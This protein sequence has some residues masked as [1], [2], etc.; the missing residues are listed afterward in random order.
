MLTKSKHKDS[1]LSVGFVRRLLYNLYAGEVE[2]IENLR[3]IP[4]SAAGERALVVCQHG[5]WNRQLM[6]F[7][8][9]IFQ[10]NGVS[11]PLRIQAQWRKTFTGR[12]QHAVAVKK[13][14]VTIL[15][16]IIQSSSTPER[17]LFQAQDME[18]GPFS[19]S[20]RADCVHNLE[21][22]WLSQKTNAE[23]AC[24]MMKGKQI[25]GLKFI[26]F[27][28]QNFVNFF[29]EVTPE[30]NRVRGEYTRS[31]Q[32]GDIS[33]RQNSRRVSKMMEALD[34]ALAHGSMNKE[35]AF[36]LLIQSQPFRAEFG[37]ASEN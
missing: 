20:F 4:R 1:S 35:E 7:H 34:T 3:E 24:D 6:E 22:Q 29:L 16:T 32:E 15:F 5:R 17:P 10:S 30:F 18:D 11:F 23:E 19:L 36:R 26:G 14:S 2:R 28:N 33:E 12:S 8:G 27:S 37:T 31:L 21:R 9:W 13:Q 25:H